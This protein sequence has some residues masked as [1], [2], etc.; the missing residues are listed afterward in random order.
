MRRLDRFPAAASSRYPWDE[1]LNGDPVGTHSR[2][3]LLGET[4][5]VHLERPGAGQ[6]ARRQRSH[7]HARRGRPDSGRVAVRRSV[8]V[9]DDD[10]LYPIGPTVQSELAAVER[11]W[12]AYELHEAAADFVCAEREASEALERVSEAIR[13]LRV[14]GIAA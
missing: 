9:T 14:L 3:G 7:P 2:G 12:T 5:D 13:R 6:A 1:I 8:T 11:R 4:V 10:G